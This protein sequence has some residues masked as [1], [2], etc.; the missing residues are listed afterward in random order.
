[1]FVV[2]GMFPGTHSHT[3]LRAGLIIQGP[4][5]EVNEGDTIIVHIQNN[6]KMGQ[7]IR[8]SSFSPAVGDARMCKLMGI[9]W[10]G[11]LQNGTGFMDGVPGFT[12]VS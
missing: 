8:T 3:P 6:L 7:S 10:H 4:L 2:N 5:I 12:Q 11:M 1:M 9:D